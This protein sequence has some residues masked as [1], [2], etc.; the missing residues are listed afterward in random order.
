MSRIVVVGASQG[1]I[2]ALHK[3]IG[4]LPEAFRAP[5]LIVQHIGASKSILPSILNEVDGTRAAF[6]TQGETLREGRIYVAPPDHHMML[7]DGQLK[8]T[9]G[10]RENWAR[11]AID[12]LF[13]SAAF[14]YG[15]DVIGIVL[16]G[17]LN[18]GT[19]GL[20]EIKRRGGIAVVQ[21]PAEAEAPDMPSSALKNVAVDYCVPVAEMPRLLMRLAGEPSQQR[22]L[23]VRGSYAMS[24]D[25]I[26]G[27][28]AQT[29]PECGGAMRE[30][31]VGNL[32]RFRCHIGHV[33]TAEVLAMTQLERLQEN[34]SAALRGLNER[35]ALCREIARKH[36]VRGDHATA[37]RWMEAAHEA[38]RRE[39]VVKTLVDKDWEHPEASAEPLEGAAE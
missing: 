37:A 35:A 11:P 18:D 5:I 31:S 21:T 10:P 36:E 30:E 14:H 3:L 22:S 6:G 13:R 8:L 7:T 24:Q 9:H 32:L 25:K 33:M 29:C 23:L 38:E 26:V 1:G 12:P 4:G 19:A 34:L 27:P 17:G 16:S 15:P 2:Q 28:S 39:G 20:Y